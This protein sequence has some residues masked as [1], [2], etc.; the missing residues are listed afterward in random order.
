MPISKP[1]LTAEDTK[2]GEEEEKKAEK[3]KESGGFFS[4]IT[5]FFSSKGAT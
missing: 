2:D 4:M 5:N 3:S 1:R